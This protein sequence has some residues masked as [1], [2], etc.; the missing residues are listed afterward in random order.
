V[1]GV[2]VGELGGVPPLELPGLA[3]TV[4]VTVGA[5]VGE[6]GNRLSCLIEAGESTTTA[7]MSSEP[8]STNGVTEAVW[9]I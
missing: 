5:G 9:A 6:A 7:T 3:V 8:K 4:T 2:D 1:V